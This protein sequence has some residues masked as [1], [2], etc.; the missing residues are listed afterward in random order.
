VRDAP[1]CDQPAE[2]FPLK[3]RPF[4]NVD[5]LILTG[6]M[7][8]VTEFETSNGHRYRRVENEEGVRWFSLAT[9]NQ[10]INKATRAKVQVCCKKFQLAFG[11]FL[12]RDRYGAVIFPK[13]PGL[14]TRR[15]AQFLPVV[16]QQVAVLA[17]RGES[18]AGANCN[19][20][21]WRK[22]TLEP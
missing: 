8:N 10:W 17:I 16:W 13:S 1:K 14:A 19:S 2:W 12:D 4:Y 15:S 21:R 22:R 20:W 9:T 3:G 6:V 18:N 11:S 5:E 7:G